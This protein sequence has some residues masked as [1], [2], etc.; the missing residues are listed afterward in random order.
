MNL[1]QQLLAA[2]ALTAG[3]MT[4]S[5]AQTLT[6]IEP[7]NWWVGMQEPTVQLLVQGE[8]IAELQPQL[9]HAGVSLQRVT[10]G[11]SPNYLFLD[12]KLDAQA[13]PGT[14]ELRFEREG[15]TVLTHGYPLLARAPGSAQRQGFGPR[16][17]IY[18]IVPDR[19]AK[20][21]TAGDTAQGLREGPNRSAPGGRHGGD[22][23][24]MRQHLNYVAAMG[25]TQIWPTPLTENDAASYSYH[26]YAS[27]DFYKID[28][29]LGSRED[30]LA[31][32]REAG[33]KGIGLIQDIVLNHIGANHWWMR[34]PPTRDW[35]NR[36]PGY[37]ETNHARTTLQDPYASTSDR[38][39]FADGW[40]SPN[41]PDLNQRQP[42][43][44][45]YLIQMSI[46]WVETAGLSGL[47]TDT[48]SYS[49]R[50]FLARWSQRLLKEYPQLNMVGEEWSPHPAI[51]S[52]W[53][54]GKRNHDGYV[55]N[56]PGLMD[57]PLHGALLAALSE[58]DGH[59][60]G[61]TKLYEALAHDF[62]Y[63]DPA[64]LVLFPGNHDTPR[65][66]SLLHQDLA[67]YKMAMAYIA[68]TRRIPQFFY[69]DEVLLQ[70]PRQ[71][72]DGAVRGDFPGGWQGD[73]V[74]AFTGAGLSPAQREAQDFMRRLLN[75]RRQSRAVHEGALMQ[76]APEQGLYVFFRYLPG[77]AAK[78]MVVLNKNSTDTPLDTRRFSEMLSPSSVGTDVLTGARHELGQMLRVPARAALVL[79]V[80]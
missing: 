7:E 17:A 80:R 55:S 79:E 59:D 30:Y 67:L 16:D 11:D 46:W 74:N 33:A 12:L 76:F 9:Q 53:Q 70:S 25:F 18:L 44:A 32:A 4:S 66:Y 73:A 39:R 65:I 28:P 26:G 2:A 45:N 42:L 35:V 64:R 77:D 24:G 69:G 72:D 23:A 21:G 78:V 31:L 60:S 20:G 38:R 43:L 10:R 71:R 54:R 47:R 61:F 40:F 75:W 58:S 3:L 68:T 49:D 37:T 5:P 56:M 19:F 50:D 57:F 6:R 29:R 48:Y 15:K 41:M 62:V 27:T 63:P 8:R 51:V 1:P 14:V 13:R 36:W 52:Y 22:L 34:D